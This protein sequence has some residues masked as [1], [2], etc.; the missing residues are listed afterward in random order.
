MQE[1]RKALIKKQARRELMEF[2]SNIS[3][4]SLILFY[5]RLGN[6]LCG[7]VGTKRVKFDV[8]SND[9][10]FA[11]KM[12]STG[13]PDLV[14]ISEETKKFLDSSYIF[15]EAEDVD[16]HKTYFILGKKNN[17][18]SS[19]EHGSIQK[20]KLE[21][22]VEHH[23]T[24]KLKNLSTNDIPTMAP[25]PMSPTAPTNSTVP[26][27]HHQSKSLSPSPVLNTRKH[28]LASISET[29]S[30]F[31]SAAK[32]ASASTSTTA[33]AEQQKALIEQ[34]KSQ[35]NPTIVIGE[36]SEEATNNFNIDNDN[37]CGIKRGTKNINIIINDRQMDESP[38]A[39]TTNNNNSNSNNKLHINNYSSNIN[40]CDKL[41][42]KLVPYNES[43]YQQTTPLLTASKGDIESNKNS[44][45]PDDDD[46]DGSSLNITDLRS[47][48]SQSRCD[49]SPFSR[50]GSNRSERTQS[51]R[52]VNN[53][54]HQRSHSQQS[55]SLSP[56]YPSQDF[57]MNPS[58][59]RKDSGIKCNSRRSSIQQNNKNS[60][61][62]T[63]RV[64]GY[65]TSSQSSL[66]QM[67]EMMM[68]H[69]PSPA[70]GNVQHH[71]P[72]ND[73]LKACV[74]HLRKQ[75]DLQLIKCVRDN[76]RSQRSYLVKPPIRRLSLSFENS[77]MEKTFR[78]KA[79]R[80]ECENEMTVSTFTLATPKFNTFIDVFVLTLIFTMVAL[81][82]FL[83]SPSIYSKE[84][85]VWVCC[86]VVFSSIISFILFLT[87]KQLFRRPRYTKNF[88]S[89][90]GWASR[91]FWWNVF[92]G[93]LATL[94]VASILIN[95]T[96]I[97]IKKFP[98][99]Q[100]YYAL[101]LIVCLIHFCNFIQLNSWAKN[102]LA[103]CSS[104][105]FVFIGYNHRE[106]SKAL[107][108]NYQN[109]WIRSF[110]T[111]DTENKAPWFENYEVELCLDLLLLLILVFLLNREYEIGYR[112]SFYGNE[113]ASQD[114]IKVQNMKNQAD[115][116]LFNIIPKHVADE[117]K[118]TQKYSKNHPD[119]GILFASI[120]NFNEMYD[121][122]Y[123]GGKEYL[124][125]LNELIGG[126]RN[127]SFK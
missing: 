112:L 99:I 22:Q 45:E 114:K 89:I 125:V 118:N 10:S 72:G 78:N 67:D 20:Q 51:N 94:P 105:V 42:N 100:F 1:R 35:P 93:F 30:K 116:L 47:Y 109:E 44:I 16:G 37:E 34:R 79:H 25:A 90:F 75:S 57:V 50:T 53:Y 55:S 108:S 13:S 113:V 124:R 28:R 11:N 71:Q 2:L 126:K 68:K 3:C 101:L 111:S 40:D 23:N 96:L 107:N 86:F 52:H 8:W 31:L 43:G 83:L 61:I 41:N 36:I 65:F 27:V 15:R 6:V 110:N 64:S 66:A 117:L 14:H 115:M 24:G 70:S 4:F 33:N 39:M 62:A 29:V 18:S 120:V 106:I 91:Y 60:M 19:S 77:L 5:N 122:S 21:L 95:F 82:L 103:I 63:N 119:V 80:Y 9:V 7:I 32:N 46:E 88:N 58:P 74:Q 56:W 73:T 127:N 87:L 98:T 121:E 81:S 48:I 84:Y 69:M 92:G 26:Q 97:D 59:S 38:H 104:V 49:V 85:K 54:H 17:A 102:I 12:E 76:A 123:L